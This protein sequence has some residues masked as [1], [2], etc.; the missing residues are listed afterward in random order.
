MYATRDSSRVRRSCYAS[1]DVI[2][3]AKPFKLRLLFKLFAGREGGAIFFVDI[4]FVRPKARLRLDNEDV[5]EGLANQV[6][7]I[8]YDSSTAEDSVFGFVSA[9]SSSFTGRFALG[10]EFITMPSY[11]SCRFLAAC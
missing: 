11:M 8:W 6:S 4:L 3:L 10:C 9:V 5:R 2:R 1:E 7:G